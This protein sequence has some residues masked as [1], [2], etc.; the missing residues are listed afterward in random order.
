[1]LRRIGSLVA[2][3]AI[4][5]IWLIAGAAVFA[6]G[7]PRKL[8]NSTISATFNA[9]GLTSIEDRA[10]ARSFRI[11]EDA[12]ALTIDGTEIRSVGLPN[13]A[14]RSSANSVEFDFSAPVWKIRVVY[15]LRE[16]W[17]FV[18][19]Q[20]FVERITD[21]RAF[22]VDAV[23]PISAL[24][25]Q[26]PESNYIPENRSW[27]KR[28]SAKD[29]GIFL[30]FSDRRGLLALAQNP[31]LDAEQDGAHFSIGYSPEMDWNPRD[32]A[33]ASDRVC[34][35]PYSLSGRAVPVELVPEWKLPP[36]SPDA[37][38]PTED[39]AEIDAYMNCVRAFILH[40]PPRTTKIEIGWTLNDYQ[41][42]VATPEGRAEYKRIIDRAAE[43]GCDHLLFAPTNS[44]LALTKDDT[45]SWHWEHV[46][47]L[48]LGQKIRRGEWNPE[49]SA[50]P[51]SV[52]EMLDYAK[53]KNI[54]LV[55]YVYP[56]L[57]FTQ[58]PAWLAG[59][60]KDAANLGVRALQDFLIKELTTFARRTGIGGYAFDYTFLN[61]P[62]T[63][64][65]AQW[66]GWRR[67]MESLR[68]ALPDLVIDG[69][70]SYQNYGPWSWLA[71]TY[72]HP[73][74][75]DE[76]PESFVPFP[77]LHFDRVSAD[78]ER[79]TAYRYRIRDF[80]PPELMP[81]Y[82]THQTPR[83]NDAGEMVET[84]FRRRDWDYLGW[85]YSVISSVAVGGLNNVVDMIPARDSEEF[86]NFST[87]DVAFFRKWL[88]WTDTNRDFL[89][90]TRFILG[91]PGVG[92][93]DGTSAIVGD[94]GYIFLFNPNGRALDAQLTLDAGIGLTRGTDYK[95][96][97]IY[98][99]D[100]P[101]QADF[102]RRTWPKGESVSIKMEGASALVLK[103]SPT[104]P[105]IVEL[106]P[107]G[108]KPLPFTHMQQV[109]A[110]DP[111][112]TGG[113]FR[114]NF[115]IP[116]RVFDQLRARQKA[117]PIPWAAEDLRTTWLAPERLLLFAQIAEP[118]E[119]MEV[120]LKIDGQP[121]AV[122]KAYSS[123][124]PDARSFVGFYADV[125]SLAPDQN[126]SVEL[127]LPQLRAGQFQ[128]LFFEN[129]ETEYPQGNS[130]RSV[131]EQVANDEL[132]RTHRHRLL[133]RLQK[134]VDDSRRDQHEENYRDR[135]RRGHARFHQPPVVRQ[136][137]K[138]RKINQP[139]QP[140][141]ILAAHF[142]DGPS[143]GSEGQRQ[144]QEPREHSCGDEFALGDIGEHGVH[145]EIRE[146][147][148]VGGEVRG[149]VEKCEQAHHA[150][151][152]NQPIQLHAP[153]AHRTDRKRDEQKTD[154]P[155]A[156]GMRECC[157]RV[158]PEI[159][160]EAAIHQQRKRDQRRDEC[161]N[162]QRNDGL[163]WHGKISDSL[164]FAT[165]LREP[166]DEFPASEK[167][168]QLYGTL[169][170]G[171]V[172]AA[173]FRNPSSDPSRCRGSPPDRRIR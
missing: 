94:H 60:K 170:E 84:A 113:T 83:S 28:A 50:I 160:R 130:H 10:A 6:A 39:E 100:I 135:H 11:A 47:W 58:N 154:R 144:H 64:E 72:P 18:S 112:F 116:Q 41:I 3:F 13:P 2:G 127:T 164:A 126:Y 163:I 137:R 20:I 38:A 26:T 62:G 98:P 8:S 17:R 115:N 27:T 52:R 12:F 92:T 86:K 7:V 111:A 103:I 71:G 108:S 70:Q 45:D 40:T 32:G 110:Y 43:I 51:A 87:A 105:C 118:D 139:V 78:R 109:G 90:N 106:S 97:E 133:S 46:L 124:R 16:Q 4:A 165:R 1:M 69:R 82:M 155:I 81:G 85:R 53:A 142:P 37:Y 104:A 34:L 33:F 23:T 107:P 79:Y 80:A 158:R 54:K 63:S 150:A 141:P 14:V 117:W 148:D 93:V 9:R 59:D 57:P 146:K 67:V 157:D 29:F 5:A 21:A 136:P 65:Y 119:K 95:L 66:A 35:V 96:E 75:T 122:T 152:A 42:D 120:S 102:A 151:E 161:G 89:R 172:A 166:R 99:S 19:K 15:E 25:D 128:G 131:C 153:F 168:A 169:I 91:Q 121:V 55:A 123:I 132:L 147:P 48:G 61:L 74:S 140:L 77:D 138:G 73:T 167:T 22:R 149:A 143:R 31:F 159:I 49:S 68:R 24:L 134:F 125:S 101:D 44:A 156:G 30:R 145:I 114:A 36:A 162:F 129:V 88:A 173:N 56:I 76:Q 171:R